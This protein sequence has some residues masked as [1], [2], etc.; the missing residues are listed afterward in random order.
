MLQNRAEVLNRCLRVFGSLHRNRS[1][2][3][4]APHKPIL[5]LAILDQIERGQIRENR[6]AVTPELVATFRAYWR[7]LVPEGAWVDRIVYPFRYLIRD[8]FWKLT[9]DGRP[10]GSEELGNPTSSVQLVALIDEAQLAEDLWELIQ[11]KAA[12]RLLRSHL[13]ATYF[14]RQ[15]E[16]VAALVPAKPLDYE[17]S[18]L[19][20]EAHGRFRPRMVRERQ[21][22]GSY[23]RHA[24]FPRV[25]NGL[26]GYCCSVCGLGTCAQSGAA[27][28]DAVHILPFA[29]FHNDDPRN[30]ISLCKNHHW[31][32][33]HGWFA[34]D[35]QFKLI[36]SP[37]VANA[38]EYAAQGS[39]FRLPSEPRCAPAVEAITWHRKNV[40][41]R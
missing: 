20:R 38:H 32:F 9:K 17:I 16:D 30:G 4:Y 11:D 29:Q 25:V 33:D 28:V 7:A 15:S 26:Y 10:L 36:V 35:N 5:L 13:L 41:L 8:G 6:V 19:M 14:G 40:F 37:L 2:S 31:G 34:L 39:S 22:D 1:R 18:R 12:I 27:I 21:D 23:I 3:G 24:L